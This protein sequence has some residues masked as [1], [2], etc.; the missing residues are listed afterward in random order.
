MALQ[1]KDEASIIFSWG[2]NMTD[3]TS[4]LIDFMYVD[5]PKVSSFLAQFLSEGLIVEHNVSQASEKNQKTSLGA[6]T[7]IAS[8]LGLS[9]GY[10]RNAADK[11]S[12]TIKKNPEWAQA[13]ALVQYVE[14]VQQQDPEDLKVGSV[15]ILQGKLQIFDL[16]PFRQ[17]ADNPR[18]L[19][20]IKSTV[21]LAPEKF[22]TE[23]KA[24]DLATAELDAGNMGGVAMKGLPA[25]RK[26]LKDRRQ[27]V[28]DKFKIYLDSIVEGISHVVRYSPFSVV[29]ILD[30][31]DQKYWFS[32]KQESLLHDQGDTLLKYGYAVDG[33]W[34]VACIIDGD[35][36][37]GT[38]S[39]ESEENSDN[40]PWATAVKT[41]ASLGRGAVGRPANYRS[42]MPLVVFRCLGP[43]LS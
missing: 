7:K 20:A 42:L 39:D 26:E 3:Y 43:I 14:D 13:K 38:M 17:I 36:A 5:R 37:D 24:I 29:A 41:I 21:L 28:L 15:R 27:Y 33:N 16:T 23:L 32:L 10:E 11:S 22:V 19:E 6:S 31:D 40:I 30:A 2:D 25:R 8:F 9:A 34:S 35:V 12:E 4:Q 1:S 18:L